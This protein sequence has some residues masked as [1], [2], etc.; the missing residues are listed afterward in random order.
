M[1]TC[2]DGTPFLAVE[3][4]NHLGHAR[5]GIKKWARLVRDLLQGETET[6][7]TAES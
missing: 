4:F 3:C 1:T 6:S 2:R 5:H 7:A